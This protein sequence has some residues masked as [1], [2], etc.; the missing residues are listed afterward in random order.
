MLEK[1]T[2]YAYF[3]DAYVTF[4]DLLKLGV[5]TNSEWDD[6][7]GVYL[8]PVRELIQGKTKNKNGL[9]IPWGYQRQHAFIVRSTGNMLELQDY[10]PDQLD[11]DIAIVQRNFLKEL[12]SFSNPFAERMHRVIHG[13]EDMETVF[14]ER[15]LSWYERWGNHPGKCFWNMTREMS[16]LVSE[17]HSRSQRMVWHK[18]I[19]SCGY[20]G[21][22]DR[23]E[24]VI[25]QN[26][27]AQA[28]IL[29]P[30]AMTVVEAVDNDLR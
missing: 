16:I 27:P 20:H 14:E 8:Y 11:R 10:S 29:V 26:E 15:L 13:D 19:R 12:T 5:N 4:Q 23:G 22:C 28:V 2:H 1:L 3:P 6:P 17:H 24:G 7:A 9:L 25:H 18:M 21:V 30:T